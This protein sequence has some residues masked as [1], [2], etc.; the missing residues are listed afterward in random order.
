M[1]FKLKI[2]SIGKTKEEW[3]NVA[4]DEYVKR[5]SP[6]LTIEFIW[7]KNNQQLKELLKRETCS[8]L[9]L[10][11]AG[12]SF[13]SIQFAEFL[14][15]QFVAS[16]SRLTM[17]IGG[18]EGLP[19]DLKEKYLSF[20]LSPLTLTHQIVRLVLIEQIYRSFEILKGSKYHK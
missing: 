2:F 17:V 16:K 13:D 18:P 20:S 12:K 3:L 1:V 15:S 11:A 4:I 9:C 14:Q 5:L 19:D 8:I 10:D 7:A 6:F